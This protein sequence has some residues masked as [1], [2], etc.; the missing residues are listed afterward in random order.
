MGDD[1][2]NN[3]DREQNYWYNAPPGGVVTLQ[4]GTSEGQLATILKNGFK[5]ISASLEKQ[6]RDILADYLPPDEIND[7]LV[8]EVL[9]HSRHS[10]M[11]NS[12]TAAG[13][14]LFACPAPSTSAA[15]YAVTNAKHGGECER[16]PQ[17]PRT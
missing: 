5:P 4:H 17:H 2:G 3:P 8:K 1:T 11:R 12:Q 9:S 14:T 10:A 13:Y 15:G 6:T 16:H 7:K